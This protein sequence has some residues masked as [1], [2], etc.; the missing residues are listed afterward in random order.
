MTVRNFSSP[1]GHLA[2]LFFAV[3]V[4]GSLAACG[5][6]GGGTPAAAPAAVAPAPA[7]PAP[8]APAPTSQLVLTLATPSNANGTI[9]TANATFTRVSSAG[10]PYSGNRPY[11][12]ITVTGADK[13]A[14]KYQV[15]V[16]FLKADGA[17]IDA[18]I[19]DET[20]SR[21]KAYGGDITNPPA[22]VMKADLGAKYID[23]N[24]AV[25]ADSSTTAP[26]YSNTATVNG[27]LYF[28]VANSTDDCGN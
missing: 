27:R 14:S 25:F 3:A 15:I 24:T 22:S 13:G 8:P 21:D 16:Y 5:G 9:T 17:V 2:N 1:Q 6:G 12:S 19:D 10:D 28:G 11:C 4:A 18:Q 23:F 7:A 26:V 20:L